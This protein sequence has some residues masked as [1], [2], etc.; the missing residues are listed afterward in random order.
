MIYF[1]LILIACFGGFYFYLAQKLDNQRKQVIAVNKENEVLKEKCSKEN[2]KYTNLYVKYMDSEYHAGEISKNCNM[3]IAP[4]E[5]SP[6]LVKLSYP[7]KFNVLV[8]AEVNHK[9]WYEISLLGSVTTNS[10]GWIKSEDL[11]LNKFINGHETE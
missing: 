5:E 7:C 3:Y 9:L 6:V 8:K 11:A 2:F 4:L 10:R 1:F